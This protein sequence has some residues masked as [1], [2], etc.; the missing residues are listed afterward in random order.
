LRHNDDG[1]FAPI[2][3]INAEQI[4]ASI[5]SEV[6]KLV[7]DYMMTFEVKDKVR[8]EALIIALLRIAAGMMVEQIFSLHWKNHPIKKPGTP[9]A[10][11]QQDKQA[12]HFTEIFVSGAW[13]QMKHYADQMMEQLS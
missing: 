1:Q 4:Q 12:I 6:A 5:D 3:N 11:E 2:R 9:E 7:A 10:E 13:K 8:Y